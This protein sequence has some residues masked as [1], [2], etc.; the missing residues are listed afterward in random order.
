MAGMGMVGMP[1]GFNPAMGGF[2]NMG[3]DMNQIQM[4]MAMAMQNGMGANP[5]GFPMMGML[6]HSL[7]T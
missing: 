4:Q 6:N 2:P 5:F 7:S 1:A 3:G